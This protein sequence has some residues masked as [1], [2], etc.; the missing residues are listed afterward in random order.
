MRRQ[1]KGCLGLCLG[2]MF[3]LS[4]GVTVWTA[5]AQAPATSNVFFSQGQALFNPQELSKS[6]REALQDLQ[7]QAITQ[8]ASTL[9]SPAQLGKEYQLIQEKILKQPQRYVQNYQIFSESPGTGGLYRITGQVTVSMDLLKKDLM[10]L[11]VKHSEQGPAPIS[12]QSTEGAGSSVRETELKTH[13]TGAAAGKTSTGGPE[14]FWAVAEKWDEGWH[15]PGDGRDPEGPFAASAFQEAQDY[16]WNLRF[17]QA[18]TLSPDEDGE[19]P[20][21]QALAQATALGLDHVVVGRILLTETE[22]GKTRMDSILRVLNTASGKAQ[23]ELHKELAMGDLS[24]HEAA[25]ELAALVIPQLDRQLRG[26]PESLPRAGGS[27]KPEELGELVVQIKSSDAYADWLAVEKMLREHF[28]N[29]QVKGLEIAPEGSLV[30]LLGVDGNGLKNLHGTRLPNGA[31]VHV[32]DLGAEG[33][34]FNITLTRSESSP[35]E[36]KP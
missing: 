36:P 12:A 31:L 21:S 27:V 8:A 30:R 2:M 4:Q 23:G 34:G 33:Q 10:A 6:Q 5:Q 9:L 11:P 32:G 18:G 1:E 19:V 26:S 22:D 20:A 13:K 15:L 28:E 17:P 25:I 16:A 7:M 3:L 35:A 24:S 29:L 14:V